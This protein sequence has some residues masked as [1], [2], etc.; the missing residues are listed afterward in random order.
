MWSFIAS[1]VVFLLLIGGLGF[2]QRRTRRVI[3]RESAEVDQ[4]IYNAAEVAQR[5]HVRRF[6]RASTDLDQTLKT[7]FRGAASQGAAPR[8]KS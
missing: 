6:G 2:W 7:A 8:L 1:V 5:R 3:Q 4:Q